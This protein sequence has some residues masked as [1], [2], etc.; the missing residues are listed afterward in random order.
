MTS[1]LIWLGC[2]LLI[3]I[4]T[5]FRL[6]KFMNMILF[7]SGNAYKLLRKTLVENDYLYAVVSLPAGVFNP[8]S[9][10]KTSILL[11]DRTLAKRINKI[12][13]VKIENDGFDLGAQRRPIQGR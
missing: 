2:R 8:Y 13:F 3:C 5:D 4:C 9:G 12:L 6:Q 7:Q 1:R 11:M 10:V